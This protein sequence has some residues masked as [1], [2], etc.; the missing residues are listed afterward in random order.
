MREKTDNKGI[1][2]APIKATRKINDEN[3]ILLIKKKKQK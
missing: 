2:K 1:I 3:A